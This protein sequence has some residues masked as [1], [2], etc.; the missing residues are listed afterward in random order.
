MVI[1]TPT[2]EFKTNVIGP[3]NLDDWCTARFL[4]EDIKFMKS[5]NNDGKFNEALAREEPQLQQVF[6]KI[7]GRAA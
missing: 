7:F 6:N 5:R 1:M 3:I 4:K 2:T